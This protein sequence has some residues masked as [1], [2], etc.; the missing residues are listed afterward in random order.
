MQV[1]QTQLN[2]TINCAINYCARVL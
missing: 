1:M 2:V